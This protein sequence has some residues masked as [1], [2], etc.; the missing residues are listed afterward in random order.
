MESL[1][2]QELCAIYILQQKDYNDLEN[3][4]NMENEEML[5]NEISYKLYHLEPI[6]KKEEIQEQ[7]NNNDNPFY[8]C[9]TN[10]LVGNGILC[11]R[12]ISY[13]KELAK[14]NNQIILELQIKLR[15]KHDL[16]RIHNERDL[17]RKYYKLM[18]KNSIPINNDSDIIDIIIKK[19]K[20][21]IKIIE[22][23]HIVSSKSHMLISLYDYIGFIYNIVDESIIESTKVYNI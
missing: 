6:D 12:E 23:F 10:S 21:K 16:F 17:C 2:T 9:E 7:I 14:K 22:G 18:I 3:Y 5:S 15:S 4:I 8:T 11:F 19:H 13:V 1:T 20:P